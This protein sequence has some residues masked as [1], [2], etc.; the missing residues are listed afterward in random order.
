MPRGGLGATF[1]GIDAN[2][3][4]IIERAELE[5]RLGALGVSKNVAGGFL[6]LLDVADGPVGYRDFQDFI[7]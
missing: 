5:A 1:K 4:G 3:D 6:K 2:E 7:K